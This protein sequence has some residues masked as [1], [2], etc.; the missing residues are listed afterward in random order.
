MVLLFLVFLPAL[1]GISGNLEQKTILPT[2]KQLIQ[3][4]VLEIKF[5]SLKYRTVVKI[6]KTLSKFPTV[7]SHF[8]QFSNTSD[9]INLLKLYATSVIILLGNVLVNICSEIS[10]IWLILWMVYTC[11]V[12]GLEEVEKLGRNECTLHRWRRSPVMSDCSRPYQ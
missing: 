5:W 4:T 11:N 3:Y 1:S 10:K 12:K 9:C 6:R 8:R 7:L 2:T